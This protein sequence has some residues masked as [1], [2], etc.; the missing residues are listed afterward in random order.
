MA[1]YHHHHAAGCGCSTQSTC[2]CGSNNCGSVGGCSTG[3]SCGSV[4]GCSTG[5]SCGSV[6][7]CSTGGSCGSVGGCSCHRHCSAPGYTACCR[8]IGG[9]SDEG[10]SCSSHR[11]NC[12][13]GGWNRPGCGCGCHNHCWPDWD[14]DDDDD[15]DG[16]YGDVYY[17][18]L[19]NTIL[20]PGGEMVFTEGYNSP[21]S[22]IYPSTMGGITL[23]PGTYRV[24]Y[25]G[26]AQ[27]VNVTEGMVYSG[28][29]VTLD[30]YTF[31]PSTDVVAHTFDTTASL[32]RT[33]VVTVS[34]P[35]VL[36]VIN[37][38]QQEIST[39]YVNFNLVI[40]RIG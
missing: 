37:A 24:S 7:G 19:L 25:S 29:A 32:G 6:G 16:D 21:D 33:F 35:T 31:P 3:G 15:D 11:W 8:R 5:G 23:S 40:E 22:G 39:A 28:A 14:W 10:C 2:S 9:A 17:G 36:R 13:C 20:S 30:G 27:P 34:S 26:N 4:G 12:G 18:Y 1:Y 38:T